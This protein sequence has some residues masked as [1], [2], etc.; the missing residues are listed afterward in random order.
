MQGTNGADSTV[1]G[2]SKVQLVLMELRRSRNGT[3]G[4]DG[5][6]RTSKGQMVQR[7]K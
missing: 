3:D 2:P 4:A 7:F 6:A 5:T 1:A